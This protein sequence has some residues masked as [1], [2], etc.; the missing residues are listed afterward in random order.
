MSQT[1]PPSGVPD[2]LVA[3]FEQLTRDHARCLSAML[4]VIDDLVAAQADTMNFIE[5]LSVELEAVRA[6]MDANDARITDEEQRRL[7]REQ[8]AE[9]R[10]RA[11][12]LARQ[13]TSARE[14]TDAL[15]GRS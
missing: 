8:A 12:E 14:Q 5:H 6:A 2:A 15:Q 1:D 13:I 11:A 9:S 3:A 10:R 4:E 7:L